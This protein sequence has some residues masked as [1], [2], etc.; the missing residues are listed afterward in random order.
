MLDRLEDYMKL[1]YSITVV[2]DQTTE[3][4]LCYVASHPELPGCMSHGDNPEEA[5]SN[6]SKAKELYI[7]TLLRKGES[8]PLSKSSTVAI[9]QIASAEAVIPSE[10][11]YLVRGEVNAIESLE[12]NREEITTT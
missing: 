2:P 9:W 10:N 6:L 11:P 3:G 12:Q 1:P 7:K 5:I 8:I 4:S